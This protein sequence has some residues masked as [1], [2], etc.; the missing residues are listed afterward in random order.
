M[1]TI[2]QIVDAEVGSGLW[3]G[4]RADLDS[5]VGLRPGLDIVGGVE[6]AKS[7]WER[8]LRVKGASLDEVDASGVGAF[9]CHPENQEKMVH[10][11]NSIRC[12]KGRF[13]YSVIAFGFDE[14]TA[15]G[16]AEEGSELA[17][18]FSMLCEAALLEYPEIFVDRE[19]NREVKNLIRSAENLVAGRGKI[20]RLVKVP[21]NGFFCMPGSVN[22]RV[23][24][25]PKGPVHGR[26]PYGEIFFKGCIPLDHFEVQEI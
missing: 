23:D 7:I 16:Y 6:I 2:K 14:Y 24:A 18:A 11:G 5:S 8:V 21:V 1:P 13:E 19:F 17:N 20:L 4:T 25:L 3:H 9:F 12:L 26:M 10:L 15:R 22:E